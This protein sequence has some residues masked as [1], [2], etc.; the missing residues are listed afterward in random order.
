MS[1]FH[2]ALL[3][4]DEQ[5]QPLSREFDDVYFSPTSGIDETRHVFLDGNDL[6]RRF[7]ELGAGGRLVVG[8]TGFGTGLNFLCTW[9]LF[10]A[11]APA[12]A[13]LHFVSVEKFPWPATTW[14]APWRCGRSWHRSPTHC[15]TSTAP[16]TP[17]SSACCSPTAG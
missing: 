4:W 2:H 17:A 6:P 12:D 13:R 14:P 15:W 10:E 11:H 1:D 5:G 7:A 8:E 3:D 16:S 9:Q